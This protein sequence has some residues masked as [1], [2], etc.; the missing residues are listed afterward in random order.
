MKS[1][2]WTLTV[3]LDRESN[4]AESFSRRERGGPGMLVMGYHA[5][6]HR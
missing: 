1:M 5:S 2:V 4:E 3:R 6:C